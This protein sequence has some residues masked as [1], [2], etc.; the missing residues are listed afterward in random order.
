MHQDSRGQRP[1]AVQVQAQPV[2][3]RNRRW[4]FATSFDSV[5]YRMTME[6]PF[7]RRPSLVEGP[8]AWVTRRV[9][10]DPFAA[11]SIGVLLAVLSV[12][13]AVTQLGF[14]TSRLD[15]LN[16]RS[17]YNQ[18][19]LAYIDEF[20]AEDDTVVVVFGN[21][22]Q[23]VVAALDDIAHR[24]HARSDLF[25]AIFDNFDRNAL[26][27][28]GIYWLEADQLEQIAQFASLATA[29]L[30][31]DPADLT[32]S[33][34]VR[35]C[36]EPPHRNAS[37]PI[38]AR[39]ARGIRAALALDSGYV[40]PWPIAHVAAPEEPVAPQYLTSNDGR[41]GFIL[42]HI[43]DK[44]SRFDRGTVAID[45][46]RGQL[47]QLRKQHPYVEIGL[48]GLPVMENDEMRASTSDSIHASVVGVISVGLLFAIGFGGVRHAM[49]AVT[50]LV[51]GIVWTFAY[52][53]LS[54]GHLNILSISFGVILIGLGIDFG[55]H[56]VARYLS[57][58]H[59]G[60]NVVDAIA[61]TAR[62]VG[63]GI[64]TGGVTTA[65]AFFT[66]GLTRFTGIA[67]LGVIGGG[68]ILLCMIATMVLLPALLA[69]SDRRSA[70]LPL[71]KPL[72]AGAWSTYLVRWPRTML[73][74]AAMLTAM[75]C[76]GVPQLRYDHNL[77]NL[78]PQGLE[79]VAVEQRLLRE[80]DQSLWFALSV[81]EDPE[82]VLRRA[83]R[84][85]QLPSVERVEEIVSLLPTPA[86]AIVAVVE[87]MAA[88]IGSTP[89]RSVEPP[90]P[91]VT[92]LV[93]ALNAAIA[94]R[95]DLPATDEVHR[96]LLLARNTLLRTPPHEATSRLGQLQQRHVDQLRR[97]LNWLVDVGAAGP[98]DFDDLPASLVDRYVGR[99]GKHL[100]KV[101][102]RD[103]T[104]DMTTLERFVH[105]VR[106]VDPRAT[107]K[108]LQTYEASREMQQSYMHAALYSLLAILAVL[109]AD[110]WSVSLAC[111]AALPVVLGLAQMFGIMG[112]ASIELNPANM[113]VLPLIMGIG[114]D[115]G[116]HIVHDFRSQ[117]GR[118]Q[119]SGP[120]ASA[121][122]MTSLTTMIGFGSLLVASH[123]GLQSL[124]RIC[125]IGV[126]CC[127]FSSLIALPALLKWNDYRRHDYLNNLAPYYFLRLLEIFKISN[128]NLR[129]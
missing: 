81:A 91:D 94:Q 55:I 117:K 98:P 111:L 52:I 99:T 27:R 23:Q 96:Q 21:D 53:V 114:I 101:Y 20:G 108:P 60:Q 83:E 124:G 93:D 42:L 89:T 129:E 86:P 3:K 77:M 121:V 43:V 69:A 75:L 66:A 40:N 46:L 35:S 87:S 22:P 1:A 116:V 30:A 16:P 62:T 61:E 25:T 84:F 95:A 47:Q 104:W 88:R 90:A 4:D 73:I 38:L 105:E 45:Y 109:I 58:R 128:K 113:I 24:L 64:I 72:A 2:A 119:L 54:I 28:K 8:L 15:L 41:I 106:S 11:L 67:E 65:L 33:A 102:G 49:L 18:R 103:N 125:V 123:R 31:G 48:T 12:L 36:L 107:G 57:L 78:Q 37:T 7:S 29:L 79:S 5:G 118:Y 71:P 127:M 56:Y 13:L 76:I 80:S 85:R 39:L 26:A 32:L 122:V 70:P 63:P 9:A 120:T 59:K 6:G 110:F 10:R 17:G 115:D 14:R 44:E 126:S 68:G 92:Q 51:L 97:D 50:A 100:V 19:W 112:L 74:F 82:E 34:L